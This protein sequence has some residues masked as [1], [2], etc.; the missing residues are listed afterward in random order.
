MYKGI[1]VSRW[2]GV[3]DWSKVK[4]SGVQ[5]AII[6]ATG[7]DQGSYIDSKFDENYKSAKAEGIKVGTYHFFDALANPEEQAEFYYSSLKDKKFECLHFCDVETGS[8]LGKTALSALVVR[9]CKRFKELAGVKCG[10]YANSNYCNN[11]LDSSLANYR[12][13]VANYGVNNGTRTVL[14]PSIGEFKTLAGHQYTST[15]SVSGISGN[16]DMN[17]F[18]DAVLLAG[19]LINRTAPNTTKKR[20][21]NID[22]TYTVKAG[23]TLGEIANDFGITYQELA[24]INNISNPNLI[25]VGQV[26]SFTD[27]NIIVYTVKNGDTLSEIALKYGTTVSN[28]CS[29]NGIR[30]PDEIYIGQKI[31]IKRTHVVYH[32]VKYGETLIA[33]ANKYGTTYQAI[34]NLNNIFNSNLIYPGQK[35]RIR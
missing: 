1:D 5:I 4:L 18:Y 32:T 26:L 33:I 30:N 3:I 13:W 7:S 31:K 15:G 10:I 34:A 35:L 9:F 27:N 22:G 16:V 12:I 8:N 24:Q 29:L 6:K 23:D 20:S 2:Q 19:E 11:Y 25:N 17:E 21:K 28:L 14:N